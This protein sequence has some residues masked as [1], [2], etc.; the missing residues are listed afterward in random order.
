MWVRNIQDIVCRK[1]N[2]LNKVRKDQERT[3]KWRKNLSNALSEVIDK[4]STL[5]QWKPPGVQTS[6][7]Q[8]LCQQGNALSHSYNDQRGVYLIKYGDRL[9]LKFKSVMGSQRFK[10]TLKAFKDSK[11][12]TYGAGPHES[13]NAQSFS[14]FNKSYVFSFK[15]IYTIFF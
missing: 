13:K 6:V 10:F 14:K 12:C 8:K 3:A 7:K 2:Y 15:Y 11:L 1:K 4:V 5:S 9:I